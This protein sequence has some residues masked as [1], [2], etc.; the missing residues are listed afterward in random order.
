MSDVFAV[1]TPEF[2]YLPGLFLPCRWREDLRRSVGVIEPEP[3]E[4]LVAYARRLTSVEGDWHVYLDP[5]HPEPGYRLE[6]RLRELGRSRDTNSFMWVPNLDSP[7]LAPPGEEVL[8]L[9]GEAPEPA[10]FVERGRALAQRVDPARIRLSALEERAE[11]DGLALHHWSA[12]YRLAD[13]GWRAAI[14]ALLR[15]VLP[16]HLPLWNAA[17][18]QWEIGADPLEQC[19]MGNA[20][21]E[22]NDALLSVIVP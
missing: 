19:W 5:F 13:G 18:L 3:G 11:Q 14:E 17:A 15:E 20:L 22:R 12:R 2:E 9:E 16:W 8:V 4:G 10:A 6:Q 21:A 1:L 7:K